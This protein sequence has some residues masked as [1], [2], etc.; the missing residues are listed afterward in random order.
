MQLVDRGSP[1]FDPATE[2][3][4]D[5]RTESRNPVQ[6]AQVTERAASAFAHDRGGPPRPDPGQN[7]QGLRVGAI[8]IDGQIEEAPRRSA[9]LSGA[10]VAC[11]RCG[12][13]IAR[14]SF[15]RMG[16]PGIGARRDSGQ[17]QGKQQR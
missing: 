10:P 11:D 9:K 8:G 15:V 14:R 5:P 16:A 2:T 6:V 3:R 1:D 17:R 4:Q 13:P 7:F 12:V